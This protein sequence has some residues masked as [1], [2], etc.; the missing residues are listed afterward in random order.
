MLPLALLCDGV[1]IEGIT[2]LVLAVL[3]AFGQWFQKGLS[4]GLNYVSFLYSQLEIR[5]GV[6]IRNQRMRNCF[7][8]VE[9]E[10]VTNIEEAAHI[11]TLWCQTY[12]LLN[13]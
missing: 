9:I 8:L 5:Y 10:P 3:P 2:V 13:A 12:M 6:K 1:V 11:K 7:C 4:D